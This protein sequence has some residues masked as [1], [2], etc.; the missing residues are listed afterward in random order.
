MLAQTKKDIFA[1]IIGFNAKD[2]VGVGNV[3]LI[4]CLTFFVLLGNISD[5]KALAESDFIDSSPETAISIVND[6]NKY[7]QLIDENSVDMA[8]S[9][10]GIDDDFMQK[11]SLSDALKDPLQH[12]VENGETLLA[13]SKKYGVSVATLLES[14]NI[15]SSEIDKIKPGLQITIP[16][17]NTSD[18]ISW[19][20]DVNKIKAE[21]EEAARIAK[22]KVEMEKK[23][24]LALS[25]KR[26]VAFRESSSSRSTD[27]REYTGDQI[28]GFSVPINHNGITRGISRGHTGID[29]RADVGTPVGAGKN[30]RVIEITGG[31]SGGWGISVVLDH[32]NGLTSRYAH[33]S[34][35]TVGLGDVV[36][37]GN[38]VGF[39]GNTGFSTGPH[40][41]F[42][43]R[44]NG[45]VISPF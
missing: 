2:V 1:Y 7:T 15:K 37:R 9:L 42:E 28:G 41:H 27:N 40:L 11:P 29:Y 34:R 30:G 4:I 5:I 22:A 21:K 16:P 31:W 44:Q 45:R 26:T 23:K 12:T 14:N 13:I 6:V 20:D 32:G 8:Y 39:S 10:D 35:T 25:S 43:A 38:I 18:S 33:L 24:K 3:G 36:S 17:Y 19:L